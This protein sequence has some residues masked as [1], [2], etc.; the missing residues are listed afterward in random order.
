[1]SKRRSRF[2][3]SFTSGR[4]IQRAMRNPDHQH[5]GEKALSLVVNGKIDCDREAFIQ[6]VGF[7]LELQYATF[8][9]NY[10]AGER[11]YDELHPRNAGWYRVREVRLGQIEVVNPVIRHVGRSVWTVFQP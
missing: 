10:V 6:G 7:Q 8:G 9:L 5:N 2:E 1:M 11:M 3:N 4:R